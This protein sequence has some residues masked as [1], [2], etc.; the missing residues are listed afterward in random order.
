MGFEGVIHEDLC[1]IHHRKDLERIVYHVKLEGIQAIDS[2]HQLEADKIAP[3]V[4]ELSK[5]SR[6]ACDID[7]KASS[8]PRRLR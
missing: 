1:A 6:T 7:E 3:I 5:E 4:H 8:V 2:I